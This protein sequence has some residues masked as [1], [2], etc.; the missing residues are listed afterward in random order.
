MTCCLSPGPLVF[1]DE[2]VAGTLSFT[3]GQAGQ[4]STGWSPACVFAADVAELL[5]GSEALGFC[6]KERGKPSQSSS[7]FPYPKP[8]EP[9]TQRAAPPSTP[10][11]SQVRCPAWSA[12]RRWTWAPGPPVPLLHP[13]PC[14][15]FELLGGH[16]PGV[17]GG[18]GVTSPSLPGVRLV[19]PCLYK[20]RL[21][22]I[23]MANLFSEPLLKF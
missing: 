11:H 16:G 7:C 12:R 14:P 1:L 13:G 22:C 10:S 2:G 20:A 15:S 17:W 5:P 19:S 8:R 4:I 6:R 3:P 9:W 21:L 18:R 23:F